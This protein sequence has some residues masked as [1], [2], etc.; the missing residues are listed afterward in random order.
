LNPEEERMRAFPGKLLRA[1]SD[2]TIGTAIVMVHMVLADRERHRRR[3]RDGRE[4]PAGDAA[5]TPF[6][7]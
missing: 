5:R 1:V 2:A 6:A 7:M 4:R 3:S